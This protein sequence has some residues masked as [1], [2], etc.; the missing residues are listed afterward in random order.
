MAGI[1]ARLHPRPDA[2]GDDVPQAEP[3]KP[4]KSHL[5]DN[6]IAGVLAIIPIAV[7]WWVITFLVRVLIDMG[8]PA[9]RGLARVLRPEF[10]FA[11]DLIL[12]SALQAVIAVALVIAFIIFLGAFTRNVAG[13]RLVRW[14]E[15]L[16]ERIPLVATLY[17]SVRKLID[18]LTQSPE[19][20]QIVLIDFPSPEMKTV[21][22]VTRT[23]KDADTGE[24]LAAVFVPTTPNPTNGYLEIVPMSKLTKTNWDMDDAMNFII[25]GGAVGPD[26]MHYSKEPSPLEASPDL[27]NP[28]GG[29]V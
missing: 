22:I 8:T 12:N 1:R 7:T 19:G 29:N 24:E 10:P 3:K 4:K 16:I 17:G 5:R 2:K 15:S 23:M 14:A 26:A 21:G 20:Q 13:R 27:S 25:S 28:S 9:V 11:A 18:A 6:L